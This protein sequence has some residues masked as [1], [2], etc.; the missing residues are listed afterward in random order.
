M[1]VQRVVVTSQKLLKTETKALL[2][3]NRKSYNMWRR[4]AQ[5]RMTLSDLEWPFDASLA[6]SAVAELF[7]V[8]V[9]PYKY[10][11]LITYLWHR[12]FRI[13]IIDLSMEQS[14]SSV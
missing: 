6:S 10:S 1:D 12:P 3:A 7:I 4:L 2:S 9:E 13:Q 11:Y 14:S 8:S 5:Q